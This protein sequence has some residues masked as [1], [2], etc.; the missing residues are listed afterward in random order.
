MLYKKK[1]KNDYFILHVPFEKQTLLIDTAD[2]FHILQD[3]YSTCILLPA[4]L[5]AL[6]SLGG[7]C[8]HH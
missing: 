6:C 4:L 3:G 2:L 8:D 7:T 1:H 5:S